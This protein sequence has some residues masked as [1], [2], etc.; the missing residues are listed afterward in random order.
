MGEQGARPNA[1]PRVGQL[2]RSAKILIMLYSIDSS[3]RQIT[4]I[5]HAKEFA[6]WR[7][8]LTPTEIDAI[9]AELEGKIVSAEV[10]TASWMPGA[11]WSHTP[12]ESI[13]VKACRLDEEAAARCFGL[14]VWE[15]FMEHP[16]DWSFGR[17]EK[18][19]VPIEG[20][21]YFRI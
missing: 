2:Q 11:D 19:G 8:R 16:E 1:L 15:V 14:F 18:G 12:F 21:T 7:S 6:V 20:L 10:H 9:K 17:F 13:Y 4:T 3:K 5:P